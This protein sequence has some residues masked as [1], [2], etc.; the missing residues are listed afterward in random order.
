MNLLPA[1]REGAGF[2]LADG[3]YVQR[4]LPAA[5]A[6]AG[7]I[8]AGLRASALSLERRPGS[9]ELPGKVKLAE[10]SGSDT[11]VHAAWAAGDVVAQLSGVHRFSLGEPVRF[12]FDSA[13]TYIF[14]ATGALLAAPGRKGREE[15]FD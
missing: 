1:R 3:L 4:T 13:Q 7:G 11:F 5:T 9:L 15:Q 6:G 14:D 12:Y 8:T 2:T 10:I